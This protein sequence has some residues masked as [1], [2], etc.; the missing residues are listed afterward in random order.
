MSYK[1][2]KKI[3]EIRRRVYYIQNV[4]IN[5][6]VETIQKNKTEIMKVKNTITENTITELT[7]T[8][9]DKAKESINLR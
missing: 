1:N 5:K 3:N 6:K 7:I 2:T 8:R 9:L 4:N